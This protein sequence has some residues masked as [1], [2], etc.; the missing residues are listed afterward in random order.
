[1]QR[2]I[3][4]RTDRRP[5]L[6]QLPVPQRA[7]K[8]SSVVHGAEP[9]PRHQVGAGRDGG[10]RLDR[11]QGNLAHQPQQVG[12][13]LPVEPLRPHRDSPGITPGQVVPHHCWQGSRN[14]K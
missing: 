6:D 2:K 11:Q 13:P 10:R 9:T 4:G 1:M 3:L 5:K 12:L 14:S 8:I 7:V